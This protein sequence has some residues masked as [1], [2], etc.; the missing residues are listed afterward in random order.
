MS[1]EQHHDIARLHEL[2]VSELTD[3][4]IFLIGLDGQIRSWNPGVERFFGYTE[5]EFTGRD[6]SDL[7]TT[8]D[9]AV[10]APQEEMEVARREG[11]SSDMRWHLRKNQSRVFVEGMLIAIRDEAGAIVNFA[12]IARAVHPRHVVGTLLKTVLDETADAIYA[13][14]KQGR[15]VFANSQFARILDRSIEELIGR[16]REDVLTAAVAADAGA[17]DES[18]MQGNHAR[19]VEERLTSHSGE[20]VFL[21]SK[22]PWRDDAGKTIGLVSISQDITARK[23]FEQER[24]RL[25]R[26]VRRSNAELA[27][28]SHVV[29]HDL[30]TPLQMGSAT[31]ARPRKGEANSDVCFRC[32]VAA[33]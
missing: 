31:E 20:R 26:E 27:A 21:S 2:L 30:R 9:K 1:P 16:T 8:E 25:L 12:K 18:I 11:R 4:A 14:D 10:A 7:F 29:A 22:A 15:Y 6:F 17:T 19:M 28:F 23:T 13:M 33:I 24:E 32:P 3:F 5:A